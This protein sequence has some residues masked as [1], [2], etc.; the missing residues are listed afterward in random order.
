MAPTKVSKDQSPRKTSDKSPKIAK[1][2]QDLLFLWAAW[3]TSASKGTNVSLSLTA[4]VPK[5][6]PVFIYT[7]LLWWVTYADVRG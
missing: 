7:V 5:F 6:L 4:K 3:Q 2:E 1:A